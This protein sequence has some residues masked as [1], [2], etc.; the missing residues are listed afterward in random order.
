MQWVLAAMFVFVGQA[1]RATD[2]D[3]EDDQTLTVAEKKQ[4]KAVQDNL[5]AAAK[6]PDKQA[7][8][9]DSLRTVLVQ[10]SQPSDQSVDKLAGDLAKNIGGGNIGVRDSVLITKKL[11]KFLNKGD[12]SFKSNSALTK[13]MEGI[14]QTSGL[15]Q[16]QRNQLYNSILTVV[17]TADGNARNK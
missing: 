1:A 2:D 5:T 15:N 13:D 3:I 6:N 8:L 4:L 16:D 9:A 14:V 17:S 7:A 12:F 11:M 10:N